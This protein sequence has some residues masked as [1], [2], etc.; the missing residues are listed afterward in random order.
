MAGGPERPE[1]LPGPPGDLTRSV[2]RRKEASFGTFEHDACQSAIFENSGVD[3]DAVVLVLRKE[4]W[5]MAMHHDALDFVSRPEE[6]V[7]DPEKIVPRAAGRA[8][9]RVSVR[10]ERRCKDRPRDGVPYR[11]RTC[12]AVRACAPVARHGR[13]S[14]LWRWRAAAILCRKTRGWRL[15]RTGTNEPFR[16]G[17]REPRAAEPRGCRAAPRRIAERRIARGG[18]ARRL[19]PVRDRCSHPGRRL[20]PRP[21]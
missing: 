5:R 16:P 17:R 15:H 8:R 19:T 12:G 1:K 21:V 4:A 14:T 2:P 9:R 20:R 13:G 3:V 11:P 18:R 10:R 6:R 7:A